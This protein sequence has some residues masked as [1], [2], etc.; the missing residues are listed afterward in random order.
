MLP[1][2]YKAIKWRRKPYSQKLHVSVWT[3]NKLNEV[4]RA[5]ILMP[6][7]FC[8][9]TIKRDE[10]KNILSISLVVIRLIPL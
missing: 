9:S 5:I 2:G 7:G 8:F 1:K 10:I 3:T 4:V 6:Y